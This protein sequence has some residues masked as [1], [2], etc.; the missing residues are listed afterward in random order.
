[1]LSDPTFNS[2]AAMILGLVLLVVGGELL[3]R[4]AS[5]LAAALSVPPLVVGLTVV[6]FGTSAPELAVSVKAA[7]TGNADLAVGN[8]VGSNIFNVLFILG[9]SAIIIPLTVSIDLIRRDVPL[10]ILASCVL[11][12]MSVDGSISRGE[13]AVLSIGLV[14]YTVSTILTAK[15]SVAAPAV[16]APKVSESL[17]SPESADLSPAQQPVGVRQVSI[18]LVMAVVGLAL[19]A[20]GSDSLVGGAVQIAGALGVSQLVIGLTI[21]A[22]G[23]SLPEVVTSLVAAVRGERD[24]AVGN[25]VGSNLFNILCVLGVSGLLSAQ[26][27]PVSDAARQFDLPVMTAVAVACLPVFISGHS[28]SRWEGILFVAVF[29]AYLAIVVAA[30]GNEQW[31]VGGTTAMWLAAPL[32]LLAVLPLPPLRR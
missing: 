6:A 2:L 20:V 4:G 27:I 13:A 28:I 25:V 5:R 24:L 15:R 22:A 18:S 1:M 32:L 11:W 7:W 3:V 17:M 21:V 9:C 31:T 12:G 29:V 19:L 30:A 23:T 14:A 10:M 16:A 26:P 8:V